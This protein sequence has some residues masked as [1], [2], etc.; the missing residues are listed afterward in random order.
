MEFVNFHAAV[1]APVAKPQRPPIAAQ[2][3]E[4]PAR[5][6]TRAVH[7]D[8]WGVLETPIYERS[9]LGAGTVLEGPTIVEEPAST[10]VVFPGQTLRVDEWGNLLITIGAR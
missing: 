6:D 5:R 3:P 8:Q 9:V 2:G 1:T 4:A 7:F 10:T